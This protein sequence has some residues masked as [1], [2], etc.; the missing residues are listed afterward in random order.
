MFLVG[1]AGRRLT[2]E[3]A[4]I[5][6]APPGGWGI[7]PAGNLEAASPSSRGPYIRAPQITQQPPGLP[8]PGGIVPKA[9]LPPSCIAP[10]MWKAQVLR[11]RQNWG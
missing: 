2:R 11:G 10:S 7:G 1:P 5:P 6:E 9:G 4:G 3:R 8:C